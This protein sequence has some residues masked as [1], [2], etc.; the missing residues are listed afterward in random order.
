[1]EMRRRC[2]GD[3]EMNSITKRQQASRMAVNL[4]APRA[5]PIQ[6][7][8]SAICEAACGARS[9][10]AVLV[11]APAGFG[12]TTAMSQIRSRLESSGVTTAWLTCDAADNDPARFS[13]NLAAA[14]AQL[15]LAHSGRDADEVQPSLSALDT[16]DRLRRI[17]SPFAIFLDDLEHL[18]ESA[19]LGLLAQ[20][21][22]QL[23]RHGL[24]VIGTRTRP[25]IGL[26]RLR[27]HGELVE[28]DASS[29]RF[30]LDET[31]EFF[32][33]KRHLAIPLDE[34][35]QL[36]QS[37]EG[38][39]AAIWLASVALER[40]VR[41]GDFIARFSGSDK[42]VAEYLTEDVLNRQPAAIRNFL[43]RTS[44]LKSLSPALCDAILRRSDSA[45]ML[46]KLERSNLFLTSIDGPER[47]Y[48]YHSLFA[49]FLREQ[50]ALE[51]PDEVC[52]L[53]IEASCWNEDQGHV[54]P[55]IDYAIDA[56]DY[57][58]ALTLLSSHADC[59]LS[60]GRW[61]LLS[62]W[63]GAIPLQLIAAYPVLQVA[64][65]LA[66]YFTRGAHEA[67][68]CMEQPELEKATDQLVIT[69]LR[70]LR[71]LLLASID[72]HE[73]A[74]EVGL[75]ALST[76]PTGNSFADNVLAN[77]MAVAFAF[78]GEYDEARKLLDA[79]RNTQGE[80]PNAFGLMYTEAVEGMIDMQE[81]RLRQATARFRMA[82][83]ATGAPSY[84]YTT[85][86]AWAGVLYAHALYEANELEQAARLL[87][88]YVPMTKEIGLP[89]H[90]I[91]GHV[92]L[93][94]IAIANGDVH[95]ASQLLS[96]LEYLGHHRHVVRAVA[97]AKL[98]RARLLLMQ[99]DL[100]AAQ[101]ELER[102][103]F[104]EV[105][106]RC[107]V[108]RLSANDVDYLELGRLRW[109]ILAGKGRE[110]LPIIESAISVANSERRL[111]R[112]MKLAVLKSLALEAA[113]DYAAAT[114]QMGEVLKAASHEG[115]MRL[116]LD[117]GT[118]ARNIIVRLERSARMEPERL[119]DPILLDYLQRLLAGFGPGPQDGVGQ[120][121]NDDGGMVPP[122][123]AAETKV[124][125]LLA[126]GYSNRA[127][128][129]KLFVSDS[130]VRTHVR[131]I[132]LKLDTHSRVQAI[133]KARLLG[134]IS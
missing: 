21:L 77:I 16:I 45:E 119:R 116:V 94:R 127:M 8:R 122:L 106:K 107:K 15:K 108:L 5:S 80:S 102:A 34:L 54:V 133:A 101:S 97:S 37:T 22:D 79:A 125:E 6:I 32:N 121:A 23:P 91:T 47:T 61:R 64:H 131:N 73:D 25:D 28:I 30:S 90:M 13:C 9:A 74:Y 71:P 126:A 42:A 88:V 50:F 20:L 49:S 66:L 18:Q 43:L 134:L 99:G 48:R 113:G 29:L 39:V 129:E 92:T 4:N 51:M 59:F 44:I 112:A 67:I 115:I 53:R 46:D 12:K 78:K 26:A 109:L 24:I 57:D 38:W 98:E 69:H 89:D 128:S 95:H 117:E 2:A 52:R 70:A 83:A 111:R 81:G 93:A 56:L 118:R 40:H 60:G 3:T 11:S 87:Q 110:A 75:T 10:K 96:E 103:S 82:V 76:F 84:G 35:R 72:R 55:A 31:V 58:R 14:V 104:P 100:S 62:R 7:Q 33:D 105:W 63:F 65:I 19:V 124:L 132:S 85:G 86:N 17:P 114:I 123:T 41:H 120:L 36:H 1:M 68:K 27:V 130:T